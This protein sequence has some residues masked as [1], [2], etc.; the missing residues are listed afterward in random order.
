M[1]ELFGSSNVFP[2]VRP[3]QPSGPLNQNKKGKG[4]AKG[5]GKGRGEVPPEDF[6][7]H[8]DE[9]WVLA[10]SP[11]GSVLAS[12]GKDR[13]VGVWDARKDVWMKGFKGHQK[14]VSVRA[15]QFSLLLIRLMK[16]D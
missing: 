7:G 13:R 6:A 2:K 1:T 11:D 16:N 8:T 10:L 15:S 4:R 3:P 14:A 5:K 9:V 12:G